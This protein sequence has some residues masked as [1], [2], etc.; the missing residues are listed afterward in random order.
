MIMYSDEKFFILKLLFSPLPPNR[1]Q[2][3]LFAVFYL[4]I[5]RFTDNY[6]PFRWN[7]ILDD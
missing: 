7:S 2:F 3:G 5:I 6:D 1:Q 4:I